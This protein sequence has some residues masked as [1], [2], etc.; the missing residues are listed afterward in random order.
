LKRDI[1]IDYLRSSAIVAVVAH[2]AALAYTTFSSY[3]PVHYERSTAP[4]VDT[5][6]FLPLD[7]LTGWIDIFSMS[8]LFFI[9]GLFISSSITRKG[10]SHFLADRAKRLGIPFF[11][12]IF[13]L[14]PIAFYPSWL[15]RETISAEGFLSL[16]FTN[17]VWS[18]GP[19]WFISVL[20]LFCA[21]AAIAYRFFPKLMKRFS[22]SAES[23]GGLVLVVLAVNIMAVIPVHMF[24]GHQEWIRLAGPLHFPASRFLLYLSLFLLGVA[25]GSGGLERSL[26]HENLRFWPLWLIIGAFAYAVHAILLSV[27]L[28]VTPGWEMKLGMATAFSLCCG[29]TILAALGL[30]RSSFRR[31]WPV[32]DNFCENSYGIYIFHYGFVTWVQFGL[33]AEPAPAFV[34]FIITFSVALTASWLLSAVLQKTWA[35]KV[36]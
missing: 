26:S 9:S 2:H 20:L 19:A 23:A 3:D 21:I 31:S 1:A 12:S 6:R 16:F 18:P 17:E 32:A 28:S 13:L 11:V 22:W 14:S 8:L 24:F 34:K 27:Y 33:L 10:V 15:L 30:A 29:F 36:L 4:I 35:K 25:I 5:V 7:L